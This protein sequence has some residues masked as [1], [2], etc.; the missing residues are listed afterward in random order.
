MVKFFG[1]LYLVLLVGFVVVVVVMMGFVESVF[2]DVNLVFCW[3]YVF[4]G[5]LWIGFFYYLNFV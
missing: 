5:I 4:F 1:N 3:L 2:V